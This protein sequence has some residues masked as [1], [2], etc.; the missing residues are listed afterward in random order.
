MEAVL[1]RALKA[2]HGIG[3]VKPAAEKPAAASQGSAEKQVQEATANPYTKA[4]RLEDSYPIHYNHYKALRSLDSLNDFVWKNEA[5]FRTDA[6]A[7]QQVR[8]K[9]AR[10]AKGQGIDRAFPFDV[11]AETTATAEVETNQTPGLAGAGSRKRSPEETEMFK[12]IGYMIHNNQKRADEIS[13]RWNI[14]PMTTDV[15]EA[16][17]FLAKWKELDDDPFG[18]GF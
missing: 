15:D 13:A 2:E 11:T 18:S 12:Q 17:L 4:Q 3:Q 7:L 8:V 14:N 16:K 9:W 10:L 6:E 1:T 5:L